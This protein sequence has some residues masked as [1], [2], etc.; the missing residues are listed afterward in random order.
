VVNDEEQMI[1]SA[2]LAARDS[3]AA[4]IGD[5]CNIESRA[6]AV[7]IFLGEP[8]QRKRHVSSV[9]RNELA[10]VGRA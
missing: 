10:S 7:A 6:D 3:N 9:S 1:L 5:A 8:V 2:G 4:L